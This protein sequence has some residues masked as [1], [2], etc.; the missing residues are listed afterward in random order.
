MICGVQAN[1]TTAYPGLHFLCLVA[2]MCLKSYE[3]CTNFACK[4]SVCKHQHPTKS[5]STLSLEMN[6]AHSILV[7]ISLQF[8]A[9]DLIIEVWLVLLDPCSHLYAGLK[10]TNIG[11]SYCNLVLFD[12]CFGCYRLPF[13]SNPQVFGR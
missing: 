5:V 6:P 1:F 9:S 13:A 7:H 10:P 11:R 12:Q 8:R 2:G 4:M 3:N